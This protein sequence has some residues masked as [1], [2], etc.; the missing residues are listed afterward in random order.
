MNIFQVAAIS[1]ERD[2]MAQTLL[3]KI[4]T[5]WPIEWID[6]SYLQGLEQQDNALKL[7]GR[8]AESDTSCAKAKETGVQW[9]V[10]A[11][12][13]YNQHTF[14]PVFSLGL[15]SYNTPSSKLVGIFI[16]NTMNK[17]TVTCALA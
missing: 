8:I 5:R 15:N 9:L 4:K 1:Y 7:L 12:S 3:K 6:G 10:L 11:L 14:Q 2:D 13:I 17:L 16:Y